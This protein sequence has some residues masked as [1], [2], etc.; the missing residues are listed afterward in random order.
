MNSLKIREQWELKLLEPDHAMTLFQVIDANR[1]YLQPWFQWVDQTSTSS[2]I[3]GFIKG[4]W[5]GYK[6]EQE[7]HFGI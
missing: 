1:T 7:V 5:S 4:A 3:E 6:K 2:D